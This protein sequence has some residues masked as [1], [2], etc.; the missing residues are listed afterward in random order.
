[1]RAVQAGADIILLPPDPEVA[2]QSLVRAVPRGPARRGAPRRLGAA[3]PGG[4]GAARPAQ[5]PAAWTPPRSGSVGR[6]EDVERALDDGAPLDHRRAQ[7]GRRAARSTPR[8]RCASSTWCCPATRATT[9][10]RA[11]PRR[12]W[13][14]AACRRETVSLGPEVSEETARAAS[15]RGPRASR[16]W[17]RRASCGWRG[18]EGTADMSESHARLLQALARGGPAADRG[19]LRQPVPA[20]AV[21]GRPG[22]RVRVRRRGIQPARGGGRALRRVC[23]RG[24]AAGDAAGAVPL[25]PWPGDPEA[26]DDAARGAPRGGRVPRRRPGGAWTA[27]WSGGRGAGASRAA[28]WRSAR[29]ARSSTCAPSAGS[30][31][32]PARRRVRDGHDLRPGQPDQGRGHHDHGDDPGGRG[33]AGPRQAGLG[34]PAALPRRRPRTGSRCAQPADPLLRASTGG[35]RSTRTRRARRRT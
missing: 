3:H 18:S 13:R 8:S 11:S 14:P 21:P 6:P 26:R 28:W 4:Q 7:R 27:C 23:C 20:A 15:W 32:T 10:S 22:L 2:V 12:S 17:W 16:T 33:A 5:E 34:V 24:Q 1:M 30:P 25:W 31:T 35:R 19:L 9:P 29:T